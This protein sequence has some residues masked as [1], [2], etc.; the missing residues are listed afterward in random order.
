M[1]SR[2]EPAPEPDPLAGKLRG[3]G[4]LGALAM[5]V[6]TAMGPII[7]PLGAL[8]VLAWARRSRTPWS[9][10]GFARPR[11]WI[12]PIAAGIVF[13]SLFKILMKGIVMPILGADPINQAY[14]YIAGNAVAL[15]GILFAA[16]L[17]AGFGEETVY[18]GYLFERLGKLFGHGAVAK[19]AIVVLTSALFAA[20]HYPVQGAAGVEQAAITG[21]VFGTIY[22]IT[23]R[24]WTVMIAH[25]AFDVTA[26]FIIYW[27]LESYVA[28]LIFR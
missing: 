4:P 14:H 11:T 3:F 26:V 16:T 10:I 22:A 27:D 17:G 20:V 19:A 12:G 25:A 8:L 5:L 9:A 1:P 7:E 23:G 18:R 24:I 13:G 21:L 28:H 6:I 15:P 2:P